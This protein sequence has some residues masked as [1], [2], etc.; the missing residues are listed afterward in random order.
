MSLEARLDELEQRLAY[1]FS[2]RLGY[3]TACPSNVGTGLRASVMMHLSGL[4]LLNEIELET[5]RDEVT[6]RALELGQA[7]QRELLQR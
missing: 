2:P 3:L 6:V 1:A 4:R 5:A 7:E